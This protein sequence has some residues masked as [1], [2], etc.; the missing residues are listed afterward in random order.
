MMVSVMVLV[1][2]SVLA[3]AFFYGDDGVS[4]S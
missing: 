1:W 3:L 4:L 2:V